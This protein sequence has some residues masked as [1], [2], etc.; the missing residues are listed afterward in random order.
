MNKPIHEEEYRGL[1][2]K[3]YPDDTSDEGPRDWDNLGTMV[4]F[5]KRYALGDKHKMTI[6][7]LQEIVDRKDI[8]AL[9]LYLYDHGGIT[10]NT[11]GFSCPWDSGQVGY[12]YVD[13]AKIRQEYNLL[14]PSKKI[15]KDVIAKVT[16]ILKQEVE[17][18]DQYLTGRV[19]GFVI[20]DKDGEHID[21]C[22]GFY[23][24]YEEGALKE[25]KDI[26]DH[27]TNKGLTNAIGQYLMPGIV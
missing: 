11:T 2:I 8:V 12:I 23:G 13:E 1:T 6:E 26:V 3:I 27:K 19:Y 7:E 16:E 25:A 20:E 21:S 5:H 24:D 15:H 17:T 9:P 4:C 22:W 14:D 10:M 18:Y